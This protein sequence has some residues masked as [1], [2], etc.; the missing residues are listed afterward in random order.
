MKRLRI[1]IVGLG[2]V[3]G[4]IIHDLFTIFPNRIDEIHLL[5][6]DTVEVHNMPHQMYSEEEAGNHKVYATMRKIRKTEYTNKIYTYVV[7]ANH[8]PQE[9]VEQVSQCNIYISAVDSYE[10]RVNFYYYIVSESKE[11]N[12]IHVDCGAEG[13]LSHCFI[14]TPKDTSPCI[15]CIRSLF[16]HEKRRTN[17]CSVSSINISPEEVTQEKIP[18][19][20]MSIQQEVSRNTLDAQKLEKHLYI[21]ISNIFNKKY[22]N[23][24]ISPEQAKDILSPILPNTPPI[25]V[26]ISSFLSICI[27]KNF[28]IPYNFLLYSG[29]K[30]PTLHK[31]LLE[32]DKACFL[33]NKPKT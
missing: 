2:G 24:H 4:A 12:R 30:S 18:S 7:D 33:C 13:F 16:S 9:V 20:L 8:P 10:T 15:Y 31:H 22:K 19:I 21:E 28:S 27:H 6:R 11:K 26:I 23:E 14:N 3:G 25:N 17:I 5:D 29:E 32:K 1:C